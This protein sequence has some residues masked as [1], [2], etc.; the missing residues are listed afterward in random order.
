MTCASRHQ[1]KGDPGG[2]RLRGSSACAESRCSCARQGAP[3]VGAGT[4]AT[5]ARPQCAETSRSCARDGRTDAARVLR[6]RASSA[7]K[8]RVLAHNR[9]RGRCTGAARARLACA[10]TPRSCATKQCA[11]PPAPRSPRTLF[12]PNE[13][14]TQKGQDWGMHR[15]ESVTSQ[16]WTLVEQFPDRRPHFARCAVPWRVPL[17]LQ[18]PSSA[19]SGPDSRQCRANEYRQLPRRA[20]DSAISICNGSIIASRIPSD[21]PPACRSRSDR[22]QARSAM[23]RTLDG[24]LIRSS[25]ERPQSNPLGQTLPDDSPHRLGPCAKAIGYTTTRSSEVAADPV[26]PQWGL[27]SEMTSRP[28]A[29]TASVT[30]RSR[31]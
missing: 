5:C 18:S 6:G 24:P 2:D 29:A 16:P 21:A 26:H 17:C 13:R 3:A 28:C 11:G 23:D 4:S 25:T 10:E 1:P 20:A 12:V 15:D 7:Q 31:L 14:V 19:R 30:T 8:R 27:R 22:R 9:A